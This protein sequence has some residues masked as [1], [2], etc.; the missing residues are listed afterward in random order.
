MPKVTVLMPVYNAAKYLNEAI[1]SILGQTFKDFE[2]LIIDDGSTDLS[3]EIIESYKDKRIR[4]VINE[5]NLRLI[6][7]LNK[8]ISLA[9]GEYIAR[10]DADDISLPKRLEKQVAFMDKNPKIGVC[11]TWVKTF[12]ESTGV[13]RYYTKSDD[14]KAGFLFNTQMAHPSVIFRASLFREHK[15]CFN[16]DFIHAED[17]EFW[18][19]ISPIT[20]FANLNE[21]LLLYRITR[22][23]ISN[24]HADTQG[25]NA[26]QIRVRELKKLGLEPSEK[27]LF[28]HCVLS[29]PP[30]YTLEDYL[31]RKE[32]WLIRL[33]DANRKNE[34]YEIKSFI[35]IISGRWLEVCH[36][37][38]RY[39]NTWKIFRQSPLSNNE[40]LDK[41][42]ILKFILK[43]LSHAPKN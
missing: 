42:K 8:G 19:R 24:K 4:L 10:M 16:P 25:K 2:L 15:L 32:K 36:A 9:Q 17:Y 26:N 20:V 29:K 11:G 39:G 1:D 43:R 38:L 14:I 37:N 28:L 7:T 30:E 35:K 23:N 33:D 41:M 3:R 5:T 31:T 34:V 27:E 40:E 12:G 21:I 22:D 6:A 18:T 13:N